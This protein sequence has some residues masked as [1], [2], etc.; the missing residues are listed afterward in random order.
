MYGGK[1]G[2]RDSDPRC[3]VCGMNIL[4]AVAITVL[5][6]VASISQKQVAITID[7]MPFLWGNIYLTPEQESQAFRKVLAALKKHNVQAFG[8]V[9]GGRIKP[10]HKE[11]L[12]EFITA[13]HTIGNHTSTH[14]DFNSTAVDW[15]E[16]D[17][18]KGQ[19]EISPWVSGTKYFRYPY[20][21][22]GPT[23]AKRSAIADY[24]SKNNLVS[25]L[26]TIDNDDWLYNREYCQAVKLHNKSRADSIGA[27]YLA[28]MR[29][30]TAYFDSVSMAKVGRSVNHILLIHM[31]LL[32]ADYL[33]SLLTWYT[34]QGW[35]FIS[36]K[37]A[38]ADSVYR[39]PQKYLGPNGISVLL[40]I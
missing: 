18:S 10:Y 27:V 21:H 20:L 8:F 24:L 29:E 22:E 35:Q 13:G 12:D 32:N 14:P 16:K 11:L 38:I 5:A 7:D 23:E 40:R 6:A 9:N 25:V 36:P 26:V 17:I 15:Y 3:E 34:D 19:K 33:D 2:R 31:T 28:H 39:I 30:R 37:E 1:N 4:I